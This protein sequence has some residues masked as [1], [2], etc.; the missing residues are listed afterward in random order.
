M[1]LY[2][3][4]NGFDLAHELPTKYSS[5]INS[6]PEKYVEYYCAFKGQDW[7][8]IEKTIGDKILKKKKE[9]EELLDQID[10]DEITDEI[11]SSYGTNDYGGIDYYG[12]EHEELGKLYDDLNELT[13][14]IVSFE[15]DFKK[16]LQENISYNFKSISSFANIIEQNAVF[17]SF[18]YTSTLEKVYGIKDVKHIHGNLDDK[19]K[20][21]YNSEISKFDM[22]LGHLDYPKFEDIVVHS[23]HDL[24]YRQSYYENVEDDNGHYTGEVVV[25]RQRYEFHNRVSEDIN[26]KK[27]NIQ[28]RLF[29]NDKSKFADRISVMKS[30]ESILFDEIIILGHSLGE[31]DHD[32]FDELFPRSKIIKCDYYDESDLKRKQKI[33]K[34]KNWDIEFLK[35]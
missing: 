8:N 19:I 4:G 27:N 16:Y 5:F 29:I 23:K 3:I 2:L 6:N 28:T 13:R 20:I 24:P 12:Y 1:K 18:N 11:V 14:L 31:M 15:E 35:I 9:I 7:N 30:I 25:V 26:L 17:I 22:T 33:A 21:G 10:A 34:N 32:F